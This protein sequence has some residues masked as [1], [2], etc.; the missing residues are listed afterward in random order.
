MRANRSLSCLR[1]IRV[2]IVVSTAP[3]LGACANQAGVAQFKE[4][5]ATFDASVNANQALIDMV[6]ATERTQK[7]KQRRASLNGRPGEFVPADA[8]IWSDAGDPPFAAA[9][10]DGF[11]TVAAYNKTMLALATGASAESVKSE[12]LSLST[13]ATK[14]AASASLKVAKL[15]SFVALAADLAQIALEYRSRKAFR[16]SLISESGQVKALL[17]QMQKGSPT[18]FKTLAGEEILILE[19]RAFH[20]AADVKKAQDKVDRMRTL[21]SDWYLGIDKMTVALDAA[22]AAAQSPS[23]AT[24]I[25]GA[26]VALKDMDRAVTAFRATLA[27]LRA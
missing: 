18:L 16:D 12:A 9:Y 20:S 13:A 27:K 4:Y 6:S 26:T 7:R 10:R 25:S 24:Q 15:D 22:V 21:V 1:A 19:S 11:E 8:S 2:A 3:L 23:G 5:S 14:L 17:R